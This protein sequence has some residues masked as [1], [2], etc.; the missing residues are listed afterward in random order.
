TT[1]R[2][3][4]MTGFIQKFAAIAKTYP[5]NIAL[6]DAAG[7]MTYAALWAKAAAI[8]THLMQTGAKPE[9][10]IGL[11]FDKS[12]DY[13]AALLGVWYAG[14]AFAPLPPSLP[15]ARRDFIINDAKITPFLNPAA[16]QNLPVTEALA[17]VD[18]NPAALAY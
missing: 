5:D 8:G 2:A 4:R 13:I 17:P 16:I 9:D 14:A 12:A 3:G 6:Q 7:S 1:L 18:Y 10:V 15:A 11:C